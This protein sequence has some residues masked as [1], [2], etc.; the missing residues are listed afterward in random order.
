[1]GKNPILTVVL[2]VIILVGT[3][4]GAAIYQ[5]HPSPEDTH[6]V[7]MTYNIQQGFNAAGKI[8][9]WELLEPISRI[10]PD[11]L[12]LQESD[13]DRISSTNV[14]IVQWLAHKLNMYMYFGPETRQQT[15]GVAVLSRIPL[16]NTETYYLTSRGEQVVLVRADIQWKDQPI[17]LYVIHLGETEEDRTAQ[18]TEI[19]E[20]ISKNPNPK[21]LMGD[22][23]S[24]PDSPQMNAFTEVFD[25]AWT[26]SGHP[27][28]DPLGT[29]SSALEP[30][31]RIDY[32]LVSPA[33]AVASCEVIR[34]VYGS[35]HLPVWAELLQYP[36]DEV[37]DS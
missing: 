24:L 4:S 8:S 25:D 33:F 27:S 17:S 23:N 14:D 20:I 11:I 3:W 2:G 18:T 19:L 31:K 29:T 6:L 16:Y 1:M 34:E 21:I 37:I 10:N 9:P 26:D 12:A 13:T 36:L 35:D 5:S 32:I 28:R 22:F 30:E 15:F 7:V